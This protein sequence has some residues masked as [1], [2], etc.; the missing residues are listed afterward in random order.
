VSGGGG[1]STRTITVGKIVVTIRDLPA[2]SLISCGPAVCDVGPSVGQRFFDEL[3]K[4]REALLAAHAV[5]VSRE[6]HDRPTTPDEVH[7]ARMLV[8]MEINP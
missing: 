1:T 5:I 2:R 8:E 4:I 3:T 6:W 7:L